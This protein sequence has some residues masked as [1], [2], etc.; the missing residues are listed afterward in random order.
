MVLKHSMCED[1]SS[2]DDPHRLRNG[3][4]MARAQPPRSSGERARSDRASVVGLLQ[5]NFVGAGLILGRVGRA[6]VLLLLTFD[7]FTS[8][9]LLFA[10]QNIGG[11]RRGLGHAALLLLDQFRL[12]V[13]DLVHGARGALFHLRALAGGGHADV[14]RLR[15]GVHGGLVRIGGGQRVGLHGGMDHIGAVRGANGLIQKQRTEDRETQF[16]VVHGKL[17]VE[18]KGTGTTCHNGMLRQVILYHIH[19][20]PVKG[21]GDSQK[22][23]KLK[24][25]KVNTAYKYSMI[26]FSI[27]KR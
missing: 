11:A 8:A 20:N 7:V 27:F 4:R 3:R 18:L 12:V 10:V 2:T 22:S 1:V 16:Q 17:L 9:E 23:I 5:R 19:Q 24:V 13:A 21:Y 25:H 6:G 26:Q 15:A 14:G